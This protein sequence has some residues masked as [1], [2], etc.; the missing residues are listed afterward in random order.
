MEPLEV[1]LVLPKLCCVSVTWLWRIP[2]TS[3]GPPESEREQRNQALLR[4]LCPGSVFNSLEVL[5]NG[6]QIWNGQSSLGERSCTPPRKRPTGSL[7]L[8]MVS[9]QSSCPNSHPSLP[10]AVFQ[11]LL[12]SLSRQVLATPLPRAIFAD[13][14]SNATDTIT[15][16]GGQVFVKQRRKGR[17]FQEKKSRSQ[18]TLEGPYQIYLS[19]CSF[20]QRFSIFPCPLVAKVVFQTFKGTASCFSKTSR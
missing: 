14:T 9:S 11:M 1:Q 19:H 15:V 4:P 18:S 2:G 6:S 17:T 12:S 10:H 3:L 20:F 8:G 16:I 13:F 7:R 5:G